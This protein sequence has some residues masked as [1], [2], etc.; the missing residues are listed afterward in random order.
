MPKELKTIWDYKPIKNSLNPT[1]SFDGCMFET[2]GEEIKKVI[3][4]RLVRPNHVWTI[5]DGPGTSV[6]FMAGMHVVNRLGYLITK[7]P[8]E[9]ADMEVAG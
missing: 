5:L 9:K 2:Y 7:D 6:I 3:A 4:A 8:W 1:G